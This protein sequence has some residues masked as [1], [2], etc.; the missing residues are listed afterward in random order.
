MKGG[1]ELLFWSA[2]ILALIGFAITGIVSV[3]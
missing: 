3:L 1:G 2:V